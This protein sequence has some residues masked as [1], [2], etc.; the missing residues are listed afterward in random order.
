[1]ILIIPKSSFEQFTSR[2]ETFIALIFMDIILLAYIL[3]SNNLN[4][5]PGI[6]GTRDSL[7]NC[8]YLFYLHNLESKVWNGQIMVTIGTCFIVGNIL[9]NFYIMDSVNWASAPYYII[10][11]ISAAYSMLIYMYYRWYKF[12]QNVKDP[13]LARNISFCNIYAGIDIYDYI[14]SK[15]SLRRTTIYT[16]RITCFS[17]SLIG[18]QSSFLSLVASMNGVYLVVQNI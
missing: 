5:L 1:M 18:S 14:K 15:F 12:V 2:R 6:I 4:A 16:Q 11:L 3:P 8:A 10:T 9:E 17:L 13:S 7:F